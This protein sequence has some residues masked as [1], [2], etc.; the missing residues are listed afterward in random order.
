MMSDVDS[1]ST[2]KDTKSTNEQSAPELISSPTPSKT[3]PLARTIDTAL[4][5]LYE[6]HPP[7]KGQTSAF[8]LGQF[9]AIVATPTRNYLY[10]I[11]FA[12]YICP[13]LKAQ[14]QAVVMDTFSSRR[15]GFWWD[16]VELG[17]STFERML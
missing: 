3:H 16:L 5:N 2:G 9:N 10:Y 15:Y 4:S 13:I 14:T 11:P 12:H 8:G 6:Y 1:K 17:S 7:P